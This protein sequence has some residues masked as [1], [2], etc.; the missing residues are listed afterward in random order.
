MIIVKEKTR[1]NESDSGFVDS[2]AKK[3]LFAAL[4]MELLSDM[5]TGGVSEMALAGT[6]ERA[7]RSIQGWMFMSYQDRLL[8]NDPELQKLKKNLARKLEDF[9]NNLIRTER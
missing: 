8:G 2:D 7:I 3:K 5:K 4:Q 9:A 1:V 6:V